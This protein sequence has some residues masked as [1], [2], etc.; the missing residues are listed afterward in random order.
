LLVDLN[1][2]GKYVVI[3][4][5]GSESYRKTLSFVEAGSKILVVSKTFSRGIEKLR[6]LGRLELINAEVKDG[7]AFVKKLKP[8]PDLLVA[9]TNNQKLNAQLIKH[10][11]AAGCMV[12]AVDN[13]AVSDF[14]LPALAKVGEVRI[15]ISTAGKSPAMAKVLRQRIEKMV[16]QEDLLQI[17]LQTYARAVL[18]KRILD[19][20]V[21]KQSLYKVLKHDE[22]KRLLKEG[23][24][25]EAREM[26]MKILEKMIKDNSKKAS[27]VAVKQ[28]LQEA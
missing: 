17:E 6:K 1:F 2:N 12:Y 28:G 3:V 15:A 16:T 22:V 25:D 10:A 23:K 13:P 20:K 4:G 5:G 11:K 21:R 8:K 27:V 9:V 7:E 19:Q 14:I 26:A 24:F 18:K